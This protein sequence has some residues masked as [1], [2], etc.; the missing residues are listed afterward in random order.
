MEY[1]QFN[2]L[3]GVQ[4]ILFIYLFRE[5]SYFYKGEYSIC[6]FVSGIFSGI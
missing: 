6:L 5:S 4:I 2:W 3:Y 1:D